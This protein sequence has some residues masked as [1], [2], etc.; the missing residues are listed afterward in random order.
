MSIRA[1]YTGVAAAF[2]LDACGGITVEH[3]GLSDAGVGGMGGTG[4][5]SSVPSSQGGGAIRRVPGSGF[6]GDGVRNGDESCDGR[7]FGGETCMTATMASAAAGTLRCTSRCVLDLTGCTRGGNT[8]GITGA[9]GMLGAGG[10]TSSP[11]NTGARPGSSVGD[12]HVMTLD[13]LKYDFQAVGEFILLEDIDD[14]RFV[15]QIRQAPFLGFATVSVNT[16]VAASVAG[17]R[18]AFYA[19]SDPRIDGIPRGI[20]GSTRLP[21]G[22]GISND[23]GTYTLTWPT[24]E[25]LVV[26]TTWKMLVNVDYRPSTRMRRRV[27]GLLGTHDGEPHNDLTTRSG[28]TLEVPSRPK[29]IY[30]VFGQSFRIENVE[31]LFDYSPGEATATFSDPSFPPLNLAPPPRTE[32]SKAWDVCRTAGVAG[33]DALEACAADV[34]ITGNDGFAKAAGKK[35]R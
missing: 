17:D 5:L 10:G 26:T 8:G 29:D 11:V 18:V 9:A 28:T 6:C 23:D 32:V 33:L 2:V 15:I 34:A 3:V 21:H 20:V 30:R 27:R 25:E 4:G 24:G 31:S 16:A 14:P 35:R 12:P 22:G 7:D 1:L 13:G 19:G